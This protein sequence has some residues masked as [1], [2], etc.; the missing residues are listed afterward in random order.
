MFSRY[1]VQ[2]NSQEFVRIMKSLPA[3]SVKIH[4][5]C[6][7]TKNIQALYDLGKDYVLNKVNESKNLKWRQMLG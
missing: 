6:H 1:F 2:K 5:T 3:Q 7:Q 4:N